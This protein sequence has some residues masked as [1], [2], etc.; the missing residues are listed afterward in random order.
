MCG[1]AG[2]IYRERG[3]PFDAQLLTRMRETLV[4]RGPDEAGQAVIGPVGLAVRRLAVIDLETG[5]QPVYNEDE[6]I[7]VV[8]NGEIYNFRELRRELTRRGHRFRTAC[9]TEVIVHLYEEHG[10][11]CVDHLRG[12][13]AF[14]L[15]DLT[16]QRLLLARDRLGQKPLYYQETNERLLFGSE[17]KAVLQ[18]AAVPREP[19]FAGIDG[20]FTFGQAPPGHTCFV[21]ISELPP[22]STLTYHDG[23]SR[24]RR[25]WD[26][27]FEPSPQYDERD[28][29]EQLLSLLRESVQMRLISDVP[30]G[31]LL[32]G[33]ID[34]A[35][36]VALM[37]E[38]SD[39]PVKT[40]SIGF[41]DPSYSELDGARLTVRKYATDHHE[42]VVHPDVRDLLPTLVRHH[43]SPFYD[44]SAVPTFLVCQLAR[45]DVTVAL[46][47][48]GGD[49]LFAGYNLYLAGK[50]AP[51]YGWIP[52]WLRAGVIK[53]LLDL[54]PESYGYINRGR[55]AR[56]FL[57]GAS[58][59]PHARYARWTTKV[60]H[61]MRGRLYRAPEL[62]QR[63]ESDEGDHAGSLFECQP[64]ATTLGR[65]LYA[66]INTELPGQILA[67]VDRM[68]MASS[69]EV[70]SPLLDHRLHEF[71]AR[72]PD[73]AKL[74]RW[75]TKYLLKKVA[76]DL[77]PAGIIGSPKRGFG[78]P[79]DRWFRDELSGFAREILFDSVTGARGVFDKRV[80]EGIVD[81]HVAGRRH[82]GREIWLLLTMELW[83]RMY[84]DSGSL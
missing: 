74:R 47:G 45:G 83:F 63:L 60:K 51:L 1:I 18:D 72:L 8:L 80:V 54:V 38:V 35:V 12:M 82:Y 57:R 28:A 68:S 46:S 10:D 71:A 42:L 48:D 31:A 32:S 14:A 73:H 58:L 16:R 36:V 5:S 81:D 62:V 6:T 2:G 64:E 34:S 76:A 13:F 23:V 37:S 39:E 70:R 21:G 55:V 43:D 65:T 17:I 53:P 77:I 79:L 41:D 29:E 15:W 22:A 50:A 4:H 27:V 59:E 44:P 78:I 33:G 11:A 25:Y 49:E 52:R 24:I 75:T 69:L 56:E 7:T 61:E 3:R 19:D 40:F 20:M 67:K 66:D 84:I 26:L 9:D 30:L